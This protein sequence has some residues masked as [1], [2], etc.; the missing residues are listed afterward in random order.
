LNVLP[1]P[2]YIVG[3]GNE[4]E[5]SPITTAVNNQSINQSRRQVILIVI[6]N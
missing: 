2:T 5:H 1:T 4:Y 3:V 6:K